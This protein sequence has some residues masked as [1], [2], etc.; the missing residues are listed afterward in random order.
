MRLSEELE[1]LRKKNMELGRQERDLLR[2]LEAKKR[3]LERISSELDNLIVDHQEEVTEWTKQ[4]DDL[5]KRAQEWRDKEREWSKK[6]KEAAQQAKQANA[7]IKEL[8]EFKGD[9]IRKIAELEEELRSLKETHE[10]QTNEQRN[11]FKLQLNALED[12]L[13]GTKSLANDV[14]AQL[15]LSQ[16]AEAD[17][18]KANGGLEAELSQARKK[19]SQLLQDVQCT[20]KE[21]GAL[22]SQLAKYQGHCNDAELRLDTALMEIS[23]WKAKCQVQQRE[24]ESHSALLQEMRINETKTKDLGVQTKLATDLFKTRLQ[25]LEAEMDTRVHGLEADLESSRVVASRHEAE[26]QAALRNLQYHQEVE[27]QLQ[28]QNQQLKESLNKTE[29][30]L[31]KE[32]QA[33]KALRE[34]VTLQVEQQKVVSLQVQNMAESLGLQVWAVLRRVIDSDSSDPK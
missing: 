4:S 32:Q 34:T 3:E 2:D 6:D 26:K 19:E 27:T 11:S 17:L 7:L 33:S 28:Q 8:E 31:V 16:D 24:L 23:E 18:Q 1:V 9:S 14:T 30:Q 12:E 21:K 29:A 20:E 5:E 13:K 15:T 22:Q 10:R 25:E